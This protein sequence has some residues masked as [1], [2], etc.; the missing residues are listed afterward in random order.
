M[1]EQEAAGLVQGKKVLV[2]DDGPTLT[3]GGM[4]YGAGWVM[5][6][7]LGAAE[8]VDPRPYA[9]GSLVGVFEKFPHL[10]NVLPA[11]GYGPEQTKDLKDT[12][13][14]TPCDTIVIGTPSDFTHVMDLHV[15]YV[16]ARY[17]LEVVQEHEHQFHAM[18]DSFYEKASA[19]KSHDA[20]PKT[21]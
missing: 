11:M 17:E 3:H 4:A 21:A 9:K 8:I 13:Q 18:L 15:P 20:K 1:T 19:E 5:A 10:T 14:A 2:I 7:K 6:K 12:I 16:M